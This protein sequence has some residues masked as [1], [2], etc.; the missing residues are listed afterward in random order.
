[1]LPCCAGNTIE[2]AIKPR[3]IHASTPLGNCDNLVKV[4]VGNSHNVEAQEDKRKCFLVFFFLDFMVIVHHYYFF[5]Y[6]I[7]LS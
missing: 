2:S 5:F 4:A 3:S 7:A 6:L 1:M